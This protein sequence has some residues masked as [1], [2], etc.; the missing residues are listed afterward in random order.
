LPLWPQHR[1]FDEEDAHRRRL[2]AP[3]AVPNFAVYGRRRDPAT[4]STYQVLTAIDLALSRLHRQNHL[5]LGDVDGVG[6]YF[7]TSIASLVSRSM[8]GG[9]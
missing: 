5:I 4:S 8:P 7:A 3:T 2:I 6:S 9:W 1:S